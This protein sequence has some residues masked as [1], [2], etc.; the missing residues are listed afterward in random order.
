MTHRCYW[1]PCQRPAHPKYPACAKHWFRLPEKLRQAIEADPASQPAILA[2]ECY[3]DE[4]VAEHYENPVSNTAR[5]M[6]PR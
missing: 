2:A 4:W 1:P 5:E 3:M 6:K